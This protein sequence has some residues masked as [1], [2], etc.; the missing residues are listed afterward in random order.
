[1]P[2]NNEPSGLPAQERSPGVGQDSIFPVF[3]AYKCHLSPQPKA[4]AERAPGVVGDRDRIAET[5]WVPVADMLDYAFRGVPAAKRWGDR[6]SRPLHAPLNWRPTGA[7]VSMIPGL[8]PGVED[9]GG[10]AEIN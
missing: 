3:S 2:K 4:I 9:L 1:M 10:S 7:A 6:R 5:A 8:Y